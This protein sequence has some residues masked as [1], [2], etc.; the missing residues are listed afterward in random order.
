MTWWP[1]K[2]K[3]TRNRREIENEQLS[4]IRD[5]LFPPLEEVHENGKTFYITR[6][7]YDNLSSAIYDVESGHG[8]DAVCKRTFTDVMDRLR[9]VEQILEERED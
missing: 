2:R 3:N 6:S 9:L 1:F 4:R 5:I 8:Y 7:V